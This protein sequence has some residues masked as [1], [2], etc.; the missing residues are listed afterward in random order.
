MCK[1]ISILFLVLVLVSCSDELY[2]FTSDMFDQLEKADSLSKSGRTEEAMEMLDCILDLN[3]PEYTPSSFDRFRWNI[4]DYTYESFTAGIFAYLAKIHALEN[5]ASNVTTLDQRVEVLRNV[6]YVFDGLPDIVEKYVQY[7]KLTAGRANATDYTKL[8][9]RY[10]TYVKRTTPNI[11]CATSRDD[12]VASIFRMKWNIINLFIIESD[13]LYGYDATYAFLDDVLQYNGHAVDPYVKAL[14]KAYMSFSGLDKY[15]YDSGMDY[16]QFK[17]LTA[18]REKWPI[19]YIEAGVS[20]FLSGQQFLNTQN[21][22]FVLQYDDLYVYGPDFISVNVLSTNAHKIVTLNDRHIS[23]IELNKGSKYSYPK[24]SYRLVDKFLIGALLYKHKR[25]DIATKLMDAKS[26][27]IQDT[28]VRIGCYG[29]GLKQVKYLENDIVEW[30]LYS[31]DGDPIADAQGI[32]MEKT[33][34][35]SDTI[36]YKSYGSDKKLCKSMKVVYESDESESY[37]YYDSANNLYAVHVHIG[38]IRMY[39]LMEGSRRIIVKNDFENQIYSV[40]TYLNE[41]HQNSQETAL[42][43]E[44]RY[45]SD[46]YSIDYRVP[47]GDLLEIRRYQANG[48]LYSGTDLWALEKYMYDGVG[49]L[50]EIVFYDCNMTFQGRE[51]YVYSSNSAIVERYDKN[52][53]NIEGGV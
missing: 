3:I 7:E 12:F 51:K 25:S 23:T 21:S 44:E 42:S 17:D 47:L 49:R 45:Y 19:K 22:G 9:D 26:F 37:Y 8:S 31:K 11:Q 29:D 28:L 35:I 39:H 34:H 32:H 53:M 46:S 1:Q 14:A 43:I 27:N 41:D 24:V 4:S 10:N 36:I 50:S 18:N 5:L 15:E 52:N 40:A 30:S 13:N 2:D 20:I 16:Q 6:F 38:D 33:E 48:Y